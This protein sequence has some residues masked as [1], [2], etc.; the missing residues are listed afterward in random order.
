LSRVLQYWRNV[1][2]TIGDRVAAGLGA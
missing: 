2:K 1:D